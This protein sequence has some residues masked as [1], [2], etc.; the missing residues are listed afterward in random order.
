M[1]SNPKT[2]TEKIKALALREGFDQAGITL[3]HALEEGKQAIEKWVAEGK[4]GT[5]QYLAD[6]P[7]RSLDFLNRFGNPKSVIVLGL[8]Y[9]QPSKTPPANQPFSGRVARYSWGQDY[10]RVIREKHNRFIE[11]LHRELGI[12]FKSASCVD[13]QPVPERFAAM[14]A[15]LGF[16]GKHTGILSDQFGPWLFLS[17]ILTDLELTED[18]PDTRN[19]GKCTDCQK[20]CPTGALSE[21]YQLD[22]RLCIAYLTIEY[23]GIIPEALRPKIKNWFYGCDE[24]FEICPVNNKNKISAHPEFA[25]EAGVGEWINLAALFDLPSNAEFKRRTA[26]SA[27]ERLSLKQALRNACIV[28]GNSKNP[29][30]IPLLRKALE[31]PEELVR[32]H[33]AWALKQIDSS[34]ARK[35]LEDHAR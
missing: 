7:K 18:M 9:F 26:H 27:M 10:H 4:H 19:C 8:N 2:L 32:V 25:A 12:S 15:G 31:H 5:M 20:V 1:K 16:L 29:E 22:A 34:E 33:A 28:L 17:E 3:P 13:I 14:K 6:F 23:K 11:T 21:D 24:C 35:L 30:A